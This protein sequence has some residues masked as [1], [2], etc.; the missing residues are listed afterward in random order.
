[1]VR[2]LYKELEESLINLGVAE[3]SLRTAQDRAL[4]SYSA[5]IAEETNRLHGNYNGMGLT[6]RKS[7][8]DGLE[9]VTDQLRGITPSYGQK[10]PELEGIAGKE[11][12]EVKTDSAD[13]A[14]L[15]FASVA[16]PEPPEPKKSKRR[17]AMTGKRFSFRRARS[18]R[19]EAGLS[20]KKLVEKLGL[21]QSYRQR[22]SALENKRVKPRYESRSKFDAK[23][24]DWLMRRERFF[25]E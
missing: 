15:E 19:E 1:M 25:D 17:Y 12:G 20:Q 8:L 24:L 5:A 9:K 4:N 11:Y 14:I 6:E 7:V 13:S 22:L 3:E 2:D 10:A 16:V 21:P 23:Y 18:V